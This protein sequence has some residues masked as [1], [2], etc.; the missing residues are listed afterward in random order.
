[1]ASINS[2]SRLKLT[3]CASTPSGNVA[4]TKPGGRL[5]M[6]SYACS[7]PR[8]ANWAAKSA[9]DHGTS[10]SVPAWTSRRGTNASSASRS[11]GPLPGTA[12]AAAGVALLWATAE[13]PASDAAMAMPIDPATNRRRSSVL[14]R[15]NPW[16]PVTDSSFDD[17]SGGARSTPGKSGWW[18]P[19][20]VRSMYL[21]KGDGVRFPAWRPRCG[22]DRPQPYEA[23]P[24]AHGE[25]WDGA[26]CEPKGGSHATWGGGRGGQSARRR[27]V[28]SR[29]V[30]STRLW[31]NCLVSSSEVW[32]VS[33]PSALNLPAAKVT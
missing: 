21:T 12:A 14:A 8:D 4:L 11:A 13:R 2:W 1:M 30:Q 9:Y 5:S 3:I 6:L 10:L 24:L 15:E 17:G 31:S 7:I 23:E 22:A 19:V 20:V 33:S 18:L 28:P 27:E 26:L 32:S 29:R 16:G 25:R